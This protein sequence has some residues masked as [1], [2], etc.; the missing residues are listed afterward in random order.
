VGRALCEWGE[1]GVATVGAEA[2]VLIIVDVLSFS[3]AVDVAVSRGALVHPFALGD[4][5]AAG[6]AAKRAGAELA[7]PRRAG[8]GQF[9][10]SPASLRSAKPAQRILLPSPNG[11]RLSLQ[12]R[13]PHVLCGCLRNYR[14][15]A[16]AARELGQGADVA[17]IP[18]G[19]RWPDGSLRPAV[20]DWLGA[21]AIVA[22]LD[23]ET[24]A[25][26]DIARRAFLAAQGDLAALLH[27]CRSGQE[28]IERGFE[29]DVEIAA[30]LDVSRA[31]PR[32]LDGVY[33]A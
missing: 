10:L 33:R 26:A 24:T 8:G 23:L 11:S 32:L 21:G 13:A 17:V 25:E 29:E 1:Q 15:V 31:A 12:A 28:L 3:T 18:A 6:A 27:A 5:E 19:E 20:E 2:A 16:Q 9:S 7:H 30:R 4:L 22:A 14:A